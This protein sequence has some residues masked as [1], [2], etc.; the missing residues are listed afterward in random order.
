M[1]WLSVYLCPSDAV[2]SILNLS[3]M[4]KIIPIYPN[5]DTAIQFLTG[6]TTTKI[7]VIDDNKMILTLITSIFK[8]EGYVVINCQ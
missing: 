6:S 5:R 8:G 7:L 2:V 3:N 1:W 4:K